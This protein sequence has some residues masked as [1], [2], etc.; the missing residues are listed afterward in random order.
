LRERIGGVIKDA[1]LIGKGL[2]IFLRN[3]PKY[4]PLWAKYLSSSRQVSIQASI[5]RKSYM[6]LFYWLDKQGAAEETGKR[7]VQV[8]K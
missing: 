5:Q 6:V 1:Q 8:K 7:S 3:G 2:L 4:F